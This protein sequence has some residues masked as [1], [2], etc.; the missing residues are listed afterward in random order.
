VWAESEGNEKFLIYG[1]GFAQVVVGVKKNRPRCGVE[2]WGFLDFLF[3]ARRGVD[4]AEV[5]ISAADTMYRARPTK[6][7]RPFVR[8]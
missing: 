2:F 1:G 4:E 7:R 5:A 6:H 3:G 8:G